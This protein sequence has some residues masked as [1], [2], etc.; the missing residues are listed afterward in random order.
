MSNS[1]VT[2]LEK[3]YAQLELS[4]N[5][6]EQ[7]LLTCLEEGLYNSID[8]YLTKEELIQFA[9]NILNTVQFLSEKNN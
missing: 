8:I 4:T 2:I 6:K 7:F 5:N 1:S 9:S 3:D